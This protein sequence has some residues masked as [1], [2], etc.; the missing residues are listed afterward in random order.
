MRPIG[1]VDNFFERS[2][3]PPTMS[4]TSTQSI[5]F[6]TSATPF[7]VKHFSRDL[8][9]SAL[10]DW[11][12]TLSDAQ[13]ERLLNYL[14][15]VLKQQQTLN[16]SAVRSCD[17]A[18][19]KHLVDSLF[20]LRLQAVRDAERLVDVGSGGGFPAVPLAIALPHCQVL[21][22]ES[23]RKKADFIRSAAAYCQIS[24]L[25]V[26]VGR[27][28]TLAGTAHRDAFPVAVCRALATPPISLELCLPFV[29]PGGILI[30]LSGAADAVA[31]AQLAD[32]AAAL[33]GECPEGTVYTL[34]VL[35]HKRGIIIV[36]KA[37]PT[38]PAFPRRPG[39]A[40]KRPLLPL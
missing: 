5:Q 2:T 16:L 10:A 39:M 24:N 36:P 4:T 22:V 17:E 6:S 9:V 7:H 12:T 3:I 14:T 38:P 30:V 40:S 31:A 32:V 23:R 13:V 28:E 26:A 34:P 35:H 18:V 15:L 8:L 20:P 29:Q 37:A 25:S 27:A 21:A 19:L 1:S 11:K 33:G